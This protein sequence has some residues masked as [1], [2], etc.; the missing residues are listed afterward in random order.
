MAH[1]DVFPDEE[2]LPWRKETVSSVRHWD[3][4]ACLVCLLLGAKYLA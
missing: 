3:D 2:E 4:T 1:T